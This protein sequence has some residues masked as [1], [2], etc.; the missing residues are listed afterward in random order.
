MRGRKSGGFCSLRNFGEQQSV[1]RRV[2]RQTAWYHLT[3]MACINAPR[4]C[5]LWAE[6][7]LFDT[8]SSSWF[9]AIFV[10]SLSSGT[11][12]ALMNPP[13][14]NLS[15]CFLAKLEADIKAVTF[16]SR[17][18]ASSAGVHCTCFFLCLLNLIQPRKD[19]PQDLTRR[20]GMIFIMI[21]FN[22]FLAWIALEMLSAW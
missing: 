12:L 10:C 18:N 22:E 5:Q 16:V 19:I 13:I 15:N 21:D 7:D 6:C 9:A 17:Q 4:R 11:N 2:S 8:L 3:L 14:S 20:K 1:T